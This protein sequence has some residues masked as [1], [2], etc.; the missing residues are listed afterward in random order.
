MS[1]DGHTAKRYSAEHIALLI[2]H[3]CRDKNL[4][5][6]A[7]K[8]INPEDIKAA[9][10]RPGMAVIW[11]IVQT[12]Y[13]KYQ[14]PPDKA[15]LMAEFKSYIGRYASDAAQKERLRATFVNFMVFREQVGDES[16]KQAYDIMN[17]IVDTYQLRPAMEAEVRQAQESGD[18]AALSAKLQELT[19]KQ[20]SSSKPLSFTGATQFK[21]DSIGE[22][23]P[24][25]IQ[26]FD[27]RVS[28]PGPVRGGCM[29]I[30]G[31]MGG[32]KTTFGIQLAVQQA[33]AGKYSALALVEEWSRSVQRKLIACAT[34]IPTTTIERCGDDLDKVIATENL[35]PEL[36]H[37]KREQVDN[38]LH[39]LDLTDTGDCDTVRNELAV[40]K[41]LSKLPDYF[42]LDWA[43]ELA[44]RIVQTDRRFS[45]DKRAAISYIM[46]QASDWAS[47][48]NIFTAVSQQMDAAT[49]Q[50][51]PFV[52][53]SQY[54]AMDC[55]AFAAHL[56]YCVILNPTDENTGLQVVRFGKV[57]DD[58]KVEPFT[59]RL[60]G[61]I[62]QFEDASSDYKVNAGGRIVRRSVDG[63]ELPQE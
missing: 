14:L 18:Y 33:I 37:P 17:D 27:S 2:T 43:G 42:Y 1:G 12:F 3:C 55:H 4:L 58:A 51:G 5:G 28:S 9:C 57:R 8:T 19:A 36:I 61:E 60:R 41:Q 21:E 53:A 63:N 38:F 40:W 54:S 7:C 44:D 13:G 30:I 16:H 49:A 34:K 50:K 11:L 23:L 62:A 15:A 46:K 31:P 24:T 10:G 6:V 26:W 39:V 52:K 25:Y 35:D 48:F 32:G 47:D 45:D 20:T 29:G 59:L 22:R 56:K